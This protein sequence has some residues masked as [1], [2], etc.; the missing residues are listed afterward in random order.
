MR[1]YR[2][3]DIT[4]RKVREDSFYFCVISEGFF[5][6]QNKKNLPDDEKS[7]FSFSPTFEAF[8]QPEEWKK[9]EFSKEE[10]QEIIEKQNI[11]H[12]LS[13]KT[14]SETERERKEAQ[15]EQKERT[16]R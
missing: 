2:A 9:F 14:D 6:F 11:L 1:G 7:P 13:R 15:I 4:D 3:W 5:P 12:L 10:E 8:L 16:E